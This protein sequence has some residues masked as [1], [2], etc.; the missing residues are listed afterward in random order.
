MIVFL[1]F[2]R[3]RGYVGS[4]KRLTLAYLGRPAPDYAPACED[5]LDRDC[6]RVVVAR[7]RGGVRRLLSAAIPVSE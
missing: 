4:V 2:S 1:D 6:T 7:K 3:A 5:K